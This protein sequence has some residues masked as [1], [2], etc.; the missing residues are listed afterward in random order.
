VTTTSH[1]RNS[2][3]VFALSTPWYTMTRRA[4]SVVKRSISE[5]HCITAAMGHTTRQG[6]FCFRAS[7]KL[8][9]WIVLPMPISSAR[10]PP[11]TE[12]SGPSWWHIHA[13][14]SFWNASMGTLISAGTSTGGS[15]AAAAPGPTPLL[16][17]SLAAAWL[18][19]AAPFSCPVLLMR[20]HSCVRSVLFSAS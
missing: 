8:I 15:F 18:S 14:P 1:F 2:A 11:F 17:R 7:I 3:A 5:T 6:A 9:A 10:M 12:L 13:R 20:R 16:A 4:P 19:F